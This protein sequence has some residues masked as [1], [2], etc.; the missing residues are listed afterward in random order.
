MNEIKP[1]TDNY[2]CLLNRDYVIGDDSYPRDFMTELQSTSLMMLNV[3]SEYGGLSISHK[4]KN[5][6]IL[7]ILRRMGS[8]DLSVGRIYEGHINA[9]LLIAKYGTEEQKTTYFSQAK[10]GT[11]FGIWNSE[12]PTEPLEICR[13]GESL[14]LNGSK[15]FC[16]GAKNVYRPIV[17]AK[18]D[19]GQQ[20]LILHLD[21]YDL[22]EDYTYWQPMGMASSVSCRFDFN[23][24]KIAENQLLGN[25]HDYFEEPDFSGGAVRFA[26]VQL[27][28]AE[29]AIKAT[30]THLKN[31]HRTE[32][33]NQIRRV[34][35]LSILQKSGRLWL[36][37]AGKAFDERYEKP[38]ECIHT[39][40]MFRTV[41]RQICEE[42]L[43]LC[44]LSVGLQGFLKP[45]P[46]ERIHRDLSV[47]LKQ[48]GPDR[49]LSEVGKV[50]MNKDGD[51]YE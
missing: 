38:S 12:I 48:P 27:G 22:E 40:N 13:N 2:N 46:L 49:A 24:I 8:C 26:A 5:T 10:N 45:H 33:E 36:E 23:G 7:N 6:Y 14:V 28:G 11:F 18:S 41:A 31:M 21:A 19:T 9:M 50:F 30:I 29:A 1:K 17:T 43:A 44:E 3:P 37:A 47:Y 34:G 20:M 15:V 42:A 39:A 25:A 16:S 32:D 4:S 35:K 51:H